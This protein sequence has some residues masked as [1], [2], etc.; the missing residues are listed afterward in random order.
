MAELYDRVR[1]SYPTALVDDVL[2]F[3][4]ANAGDRAVE[5]GAGTGKATILFAAR[6]LQILALEPSPEMAAIARV[7]LTDYENVA[8]EETEFERW[9]PDRSFRLVFSAQAWHWVKPEVRYMRAREAIAEG[10]ALAVFWNRPQWETS[11]LRDELADAYRRNAPEL[12]AGST[13]PG[14]MHP[15]V[16]A[17]PAWWGD[18]TGELHRAVGFEPP[19]PR[20]YTWTEDYTSKQYVELLQTHSDHIVL[21]DVQRHALLDAVATVIDRRGGTLTIEYATAMWLARVA[22]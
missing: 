9:R 6:G 20:S 16:Q 18:W 7:R 5:V 1:P 19:Q 2:E 15:D 22:G 21:A 14:P 4:G 12:G 11:A 17:P 13:G 8:I 10:G 3:A